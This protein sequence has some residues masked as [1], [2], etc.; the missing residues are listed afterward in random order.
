M[1]V[2]SSA[3][4]KDETRSLGRQM[5]KVR[6]GD[7]TK[8]KA[9]GCPRITGVA[10]GLTNTLLTLLPQTGLQVGS[11]LNNGILTMGVGGAGGLM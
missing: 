1:A 4:G 6:T 8:S 11:M 2:S 10:Q 9:K 7:V 3:D 5:G